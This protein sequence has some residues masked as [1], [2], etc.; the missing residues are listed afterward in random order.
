MGIVSPIEWPLAMGKAQVDGSTYFY[1]S[2]DELDGAQRSTLPVE[3]FSNQ[4]FEV[5][6]DDE[7]AL[8][9]FCSEWGLMRHPIRNDPLFD[10]NLSS[11]R[12]R[13]F[14]DGETLDSFL[15]DLDE[16]RDFELPNGNPWGYAVSAREISYTIKD[17]RCALLEIRNGAF[18]EL[19]G[20]RNANLDVD[21]SL[22]EIGASNPYRI[23]FNP[24]GAFSPT[25]TTAICNQVLDT[26]ADPAPWHICE[27]CGKPFKH[28]QDRAGAVEW[29][30]PAKRRTRGTKY[31]SY[32]CYTRATSAAYDE[33]KRAAK[34]G[35]EI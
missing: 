25:L 21:C 24:G 3:F 17:L 29:P 16:I 10:Y 15:W 4:L 28:R 31:C 18:F 6:T 9:D 7:N 13:S 34:Q 1:G 30:L 23:F 12:G 19:H 8:F 33:K 5:D 35:F 11:Y 20:I 27:R 2:H 26:L 32:T 14:L 22:I